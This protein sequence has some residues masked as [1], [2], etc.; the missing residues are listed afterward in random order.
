[1]QGSEADSGDADQTVAAIREASS[2][3]S[4]Q[5]NEDGVPVDRECIGLTG[6]ALDQLTACRTDH[7]QAQGLASLQ[8]L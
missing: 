8:E 1:M 3:R 6:I 5:R 4:R 2:S 7:R